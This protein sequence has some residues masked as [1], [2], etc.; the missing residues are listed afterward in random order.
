MTH[1]FGVGDDLGGRLEDEQADGVRHR[2][3]QEHLLINFDKV[4]DCIDTSNYVYL[5]PQVR[6][7]GDGVW[8]PPKWL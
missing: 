2:H 4:L 6:S 8:P 1:Q 3:L 7:N 5:C